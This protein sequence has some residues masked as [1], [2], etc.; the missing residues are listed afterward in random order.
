MA[1]IKK[2]KVLKILNHGIELGVGLGILL[3]MER[4]KIGVFKEGEH[5]ATYGEFKEMLKGYCVDIDSGDF[6]AI[7]S[8]FNVHPHTK[9][10]LQNTGKHVYQMDT[11]TAH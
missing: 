7:M 6:E 2:K 5:G 11:D 10:R 9:I 8:L 4:H 3:A 1:K